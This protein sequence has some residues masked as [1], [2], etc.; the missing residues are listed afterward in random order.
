MKT[1][2]DYL[3]NKEEQGTFVVSDIAEFGLNMG[4]NGLIYRNEILDFF[5]EYEDDIQ[6][7]ILNLASEI[8]GYEGYSLNEMELLDNLNT[9]VNSDFKFEDY[10]LRF[11]DYLAKANELIAED[12]GDE[13]DDMDE[14]ELEELQF[15][16]VADIEFELT[17][18]DKEK[19]VWLAVETE[20]V[21]IE[22]EREAGE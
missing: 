19:W 16:Y 18:E 5:N 2:K 7:I 12:L 10:E 1:V 17:D 15:D 9:F 22:N 21:N 13:M 6:E 3:L 8:T 4:V 11:D 14:Y 20:A